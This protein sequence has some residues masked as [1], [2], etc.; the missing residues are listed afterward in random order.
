M[1]HLYGCNKCD[2]QDKSTLLEAFDRFFETS[3]SSPVEG[4][5][6]GGSLGGEEHLVGAL[7]AVIPSS[8]TCLCNINE[9]LTS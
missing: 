6:R 3:I 5:F 4:L 8:N 9:F 2:K 7:T 1:H